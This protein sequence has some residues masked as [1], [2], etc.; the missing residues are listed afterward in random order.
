MKLTSLG[1]TNPA[2]TDFAG[3]ALMEVGANQN[4]ESVRLTV[5]EKR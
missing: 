5:F 3:G 2:N 4:D 1:L